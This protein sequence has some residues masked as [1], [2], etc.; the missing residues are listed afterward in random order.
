MCPSH[1]LMNN[2]LKPNDGKQSAR[3]RCSCDGAENNQTKE[4]SCVPTTFTFKKELSAGNVILD[5][6]CG[7]LKERLEAQW[8]QRAFGFNH[9]AYVR[10]A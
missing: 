10:T 2:A 7:E 5:R 6:H 9:Y 8:M 1:T 4:A 3:N